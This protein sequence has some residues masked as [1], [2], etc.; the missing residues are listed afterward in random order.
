MVP[1]FQEAAAAL[2]TAHEKGIIHR[3]LKPDSLFFVAEEGG[4]EHIKIADFGLAKLP[5]KPEGSGEE[6]FETTQGT[7]IG[8]PVYMAPEL[9]GSAAKA[10]GRSDVYSLGIVLYE[11]LAGR[12]PFDSRSPAE[13]MGMHLFRPPPPLREAAKAVPAPLAD[14]VHAM[15]AKE[16]PERPTMAQVAERLLRPDA[17][18][19]G[20]GGLRGLWQR[21]F[22]KRK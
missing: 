19:A 16:P 11:A 17:E 6:A 7:T 2:Q 21:L 20:P 8:T 4:G 10:E 5:K 14:L 18:P 3:N 15:L 13:I 22:G 12:P 1:L 9:F